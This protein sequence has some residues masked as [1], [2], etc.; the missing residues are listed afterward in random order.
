MAP[1]HWFIIVVALGLLVLG[2]ALLLD[3]RAHRRRSGIDQP[4]PLRQH[5]AVDSHVPAYVTQGAVDALPSPGAGGQRHLPKQ[6]EGFSFGHAHPDFANNPDGASWSTPTLLIVDGEVTAMRELLAPL[7]HATSTSP[8]IVIAERVHP[9]VVATLAANRRALG[10]PVVAAEAPARERRRL[11]EVSGAT[12]LLPS[13]LQAGYVPRS[14]L[15]TATHWSSTLT[16]TWVQ[17]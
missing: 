9:D 3:R 14:H 13:D 15:G 6:G 11:A 16:K 17:P 5:P 7:Q 2:G 12:A 8:L 4:A 10:L 1:W